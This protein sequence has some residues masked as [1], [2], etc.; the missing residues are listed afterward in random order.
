[1]AAAILRFLLRLGFVVLAQPRRR[2]QGTKKQN[3]S[4]R[5]GYLE[6]MKR[7][8]GLDGQDYL[9]LALFFSPFS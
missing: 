7:D 9:R 6:R 4:V 3:S 1:M 8:T 2:A 5:R